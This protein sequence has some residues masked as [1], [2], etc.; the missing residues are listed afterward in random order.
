MRGAAKR[1]EALTVPSGVLVRLRPLLPDELFEGYVGQLISENGLTDQ[2]ALLRCLQPSPDPRPPLKKLS[3][4]QRLALGLAQ[5]IEIR[6]DFLIR[7]HSL[8][9]LI[10]LLWP[11]WAA[12]T[13]LAGHV[14]EWRLCPICV[15]EDLGFR[16]I[17]YWRRMH[18]LHGVTWCLKHKAPLVAPMRSLKRLADVSPGASL[19]AGVQPVVGPSAGNRDVARY[20]AILVALLENAHRPLDRGLVAQALRA[21]LSCFAEAPCA[22]LP[23][24]WL[25]RFL[26][27]GYETDEPGQAAQVDR[28]LFRNSRTT[29][30]FNLA[31]VM[32]LL[33]KDA[34]RAVSD[35][36]TVQ[37]VERQAE[38]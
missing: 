15:E 16:G 7:E 6:V 23:P 28:F 37:P 10:G 22:D 21:Q 31:A 13:C 2:E 14:R 35:I 36:L 20:A 11:S 38:N 27:S 17:S 24:E 8:L 9:P 30:A 5:E 3:F 29:T 19:M 18:Q 34:D 26:D 33:W 25:G 12:C 1:S 32:A 4:D